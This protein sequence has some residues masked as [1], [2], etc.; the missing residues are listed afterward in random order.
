[1][2]QCHLEVQIMAVMC[3]PL[4]QVGSQPLSKMR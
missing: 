1:M 4:W 2:S 3:L